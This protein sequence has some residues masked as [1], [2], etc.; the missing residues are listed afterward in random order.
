MHIFEVWFSLDNFPGLGLLDH[1]VVL[2]LVFSGTS[3]QFSTVIVPIYISTNSV[4][5][6]VPFSPHPL[7]HVLFIDFLMMAVMTGVR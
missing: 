5:A 6:S 3:I 1:M 4:G 7:Q 2:F